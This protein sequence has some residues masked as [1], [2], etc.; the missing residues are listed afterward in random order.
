[1]AGRFGYIRDIRAIG[2][3][4]VFP[5]PQKIVLTT[6]AGLADCGKIFEN[7]AWRI[8]EKERSKEQNR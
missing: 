3:L 8:S 2:G 6:S 7:V 5:F 1:M 4:M